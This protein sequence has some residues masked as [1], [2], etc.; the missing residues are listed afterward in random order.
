MNKLLPVHSVAGL[1]LLV[2]S[3]VT[4]A[5]DNLEQRLVRLENLIGN[6]VLMEQMQQMEQIRMELSELRELVENHDNQFVMI[7]QRQRN[8]YQDMDRR[9][10]DLEVGADNKSASQYAPAVASAGGSN[11]AP[12]VDAAAKSGHTPAVVD[13]ND[14][15]GKLLYNQIYTTLK[16]GNYKQAIIDFDLFIKNYPDSS[17]T[18]NAY[19]WL[20]SAY[21]L[22]HNYPM[23]LKAF[24]KVETDFADGNK[25]KDA[26]LKIGYTYYA[27]K[28]WASAKQV[29]EKVVADYPGDNIA[30]NA[31]QRL[32]RM[33]RENH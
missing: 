18:D 3:S 27:M 30:K 22:S 6:Q 28:D 26:R 10:R 25:V 14:K 17:Y 8:L 2:A 9:L 24:K 29:L 12:P 20:G 15:T 31:Q 21:F 1:L 4:A 13:E 11:I 33:Q 32:Q 7:K 5:T 19:F 23:A 16:E